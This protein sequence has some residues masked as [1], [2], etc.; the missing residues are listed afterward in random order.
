MNRYWIYTVLHNIVIVFLI[1]FETRI[2]ESG[3]DLS[4]PLGCRRTKDHEVCFNVVMQMG[5]IKA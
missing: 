2:E 4:Y 3:L 5:F 1:D